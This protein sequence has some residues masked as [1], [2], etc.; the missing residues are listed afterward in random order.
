MTASVPSI[1]RLVLRIFL[2]LTPCFAAW[3]FSAPYHAAVAGQLARLLVNPF[4]SG[5]VTALEQPALDLIFVTTITVHPAPGQT[6]LLVPEVNPLLYT[7]GLAL[8]LALMFA[9]GARWW[10]IFAGV[11][12]LLP[13]QSWGIA[14]DVLAQLGVRVGPDIAAQAG[15]SG[16][17]VETVALGYQLG[18]LIFPVLIPVML[19]AGF[20]RL[21]IENVLRARARN[22]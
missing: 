22:S 7:Y 18:S 1:G 6:A 9:A 21:F 10:K 20:N 2:W 8:F 17:R 3:Y 13:F 11:A 16:W 19:W 5:R 4:I 14:F 12:L 15:L